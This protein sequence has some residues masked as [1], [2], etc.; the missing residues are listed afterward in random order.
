MRRKD[1]DDDDRVRNNGLNLTYRDYLTPAETIVKGEP[2]PAGMAPSEGPVYVS[3]EKRWSERTDILIGDKLLFDIQGVELEGI[4]RNIREVK[5]TSFYPNFFVTLAPGMIEG[6]P[7]TYLAVVRDS[8]LSFQREAADKFPNISF[9]DV[10]E[11]VAKISVLFDKSRKAI[12]II[13]YLSLLV[14]LVILY[15]LSHDQVYRRYY[16]IALMKSM[17]IPASELRRNLLIEFGSLFFVAMSMGLGLGWG[18]AQLLGREIFKLGLTIDWVRLFV[19]GCFLL[20][21]CTLTILMSSWRIV[22]AKPRELLSQG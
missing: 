22:E 13:S 16:D 4:V 10:E 5:W 11:L 7:K 19:P 12:E 2:F 3:I 8:K 15:G 17:G 1:D 9:I 6:A 20:A 18:I 14:G 21:L